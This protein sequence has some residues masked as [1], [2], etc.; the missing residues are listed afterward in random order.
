VT[1]KR[2]TQLT[3]T[4]EY[5][6]VP[7]GAQVPSFLRVKGGLQLAQPAAPLGQLEDVSLAC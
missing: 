6:I 4:V 2:Y 3:T 5:D 7:D 1:F